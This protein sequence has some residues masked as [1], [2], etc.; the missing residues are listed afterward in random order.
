MKIN[1][2]NCVAG[3]SSAILSRSLPAKCGAALAFILSMQAGSLLAG[4]WPFWRG[5]ERNGISP[6]TDLNWSWP[7][8][9]PKV[10][11]R[12]ALGIG[13]SSFAVADG[14]AYSMGN[15]ND[16]DTVFC[17]DV[18]T[19]KEIWKHSY[20]SLRDP[21][22]YEGGPLSTPTVDGDRVYTMG[23]FGD[24]FCFEAKTGRIVWSR[25][26]DR[27]ARTKEDYSVWW[28]FAGSPA[29][30]GEKLILA[31][32]TAGLAADKLTGKSI[33]DNG[34][35]YSGYSS[36][37][38]FPIGGQPRFAFASGHEI[39]AGDVKTG[40]VLWKIPW[41]TTWDQNA[42]DVLVSEGKLFVS[43]GHE[44][45]CAQFDVSSGKPV[46]LWRNKNMR[47]FLSSSIL[48]K[49]SLY[50]FDDRQMRCLDWKTGQVR[51]T[52]PDLGLGS[53]ILADA[54]LIALTEKGTLLAVEASGESYKPLARAKIL[55]GRCWSAPALSQG[56]LFIRNAAGEAVCLDLRK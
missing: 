49:G 33:W 50:G 9:G 13:F 5:P 51:W 11:W 23:K 41:K 38:L 56:R 35:G 27:P 12:T 3:F 8:N 10:V 15:S 18:E 22:A 39:V 42:S 16:V 20:P 37:V 21:K 30:A 17:L 52:V 24:G 28:G 40:E 14:R 6:E 25:K 46:E 44:V 34:P 2:L 43:T 54:K 47:T 31:V 45:G 4:D 1:Y 36:P 32:G 53:L 55:E 29:V 48:W 19:G 26:F 7:T